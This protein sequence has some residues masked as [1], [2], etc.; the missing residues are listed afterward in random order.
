MPDQDGGVF[1]P[2]HRAVTIG[3]LLT[4]T[5]VAIEGMA[6]ATVMPSVAQDL[7]GLE[8]YG[9]AFSAF[10]LASLVGAISAGQLS[11]HRRL[12]LPAV[13]GFACFSAGLLIATAA[14]VWAVLLTARVVQGFGAG[15]LSAISYVAVAR[16]YPESLRPRL[17]ALLS[18]AWVVP[19]LAGPAIAGQVAEHFTWR[20]VFVGILPPVAVGAAM[21][22]PSLARLPAAAPGGSSDNNGTQRLLAALRLTAGVALVLLAANVPMLLLG[23]I[24]AAVGLV[25]A[26]PALNTL[27]PPRT[28]ALRRGMPSA[29]ALRGLLAFGFFGTEALIPLG[30]S[31]QRGLA[32]SLVGIA[33]TAGAL[34]WVLG[35]WIQD[36]AEALAA[37]SLTARAL[38]SAAGLVLI[39]V[40][41][42]SVAAVVL[43][44]EASVVLAAI[45]WAVAGLGMGLAYP[46][47]TLTALGLAAL[48][49]EGSAASSLQV[50]ETVGIAVGAGAVGALFALAAYAGRPASDGLLWGFV[51]A[52]A[53]IV[54]GLCPAV[55]MAPGRSWSAWRATVPTSSQPWGNV[56]NGS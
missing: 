27:L 28:F 55:R 30:L 42:A 45:A 29:I 20:L 49:E 54:V 19:A 22:L 15:C 51:V 23:V 41:V 14:P 48:G 18:S 7:G 6:V 50:A 4:I 8:A 44:L 37:G 12:E 52:L 35:S 24:V 25:L 56:R 21:L 40:G 10:M 39:V 17:M 43:N 53:A 5:A 16:A 2:A 47:T 38:R 3:I 46:A 32:P 33:L 13:I 31:T 36:R 11:D 34:A 26:L 1:S 9:W